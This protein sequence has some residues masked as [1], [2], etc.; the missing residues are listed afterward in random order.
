MQTIE[1]EWRHRDINGETCA[2]CGNTGGEL[3][4]AVEGLNREGAQQGVRFRLR[5]IRLDKGALSESNAVRIAGRYLESILPQARMGESECHS[6]A[7]LLCIPNT[8][9]RTVEYQGHRY[10][11]TTVELVRLAACALASCCPPARRRSCCG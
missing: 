10:G 3:E 5:E 9:C 11:T 8:G 7:T 1:I 2:S 4:R 6:C